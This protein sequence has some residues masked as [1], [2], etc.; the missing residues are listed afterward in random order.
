VLTLVRRLFVLALTVLMS[1]GNAAVCAGWSPTAEARMACCADGFG[2][3]MHQGQRGAG[4]D[5]DVTPAQ[6]DAC[7]VSSERSDPGQSVP[8]FVAMVS[9]AAPVA[10]VFPVIPPALTLRALGPTLPIPVAPVPKHVL[11]SVFLV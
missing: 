6:A 1:V 10:V 9:D 4:H 3:P 11:L 2:C 8:A 5:H 7:C